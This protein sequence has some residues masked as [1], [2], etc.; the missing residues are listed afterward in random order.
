MRRHAMRSPAAAPSVSSNML[1][2][3]VGVSFLPSSHSFS[4]PL[5]LPAQNIVDTAVGAGSFNTLAA[6]LGAAGLV[7]TLSDPGA[8]L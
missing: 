5:I 6:A 3:A 7:E 4:H 8:V 2:F 1:Q